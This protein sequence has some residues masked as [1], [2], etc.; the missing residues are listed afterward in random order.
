[1]SKLALF[2]LC[3]ASAVVISAVNEA[4]D[5]ALHARPVLTAQ[6]YLQ[7]N[8]RLPSKAAAGEPLQTTAEVLSSTEPVLTVH[9]ACVASGKTS[10]RGGRACTTVITRQEFDELMRIVAPG[11][12]INPG[13]RRTVANMYA[14]L[15]AFETAARESGIE[16]SPEFRKTLQLVRLRTVADLYRH[17]LEKKYVSPSKEKID[18]YYQREASRFEEVKLRRIVLPKNSFSVADKENFEKR[19]FKLAGDLRER[20]AK[21]EDFDQLQR[22]AFATLGF[23][24]QPPSTDVGNRRRASLLAELSD[25]IFALNPGQVSQVEKEPYSFVIYKVEAKRMLPEELVREE[26]ARELSK[27]DLD[28]ALKSVRDSIHCDLH[29]KYFGTLPVQP[30]DGSSR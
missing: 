14:E 6:E 30:G 10:A 12:Q 28:G 4:Q 24:G 2:L 3:I 16:D 1:M 7:G 20:A 17:N 9:G 13:T 11:S 15:L 23:S 21:G 19:V 25:E 26:I 5:L 29:E 18:E 22:E 27:Q 8:S